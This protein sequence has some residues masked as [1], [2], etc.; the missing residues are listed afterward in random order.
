[1]KIKSIVT[2]TGLLGLAL[3]A[4]TANADVAGYTSNTN[5]QV[6]KKVSSKWLDLSSARG[7]QITKRC[8]FRKGRSAVL[9]SAETG[10]INGPNGGLETR[11]WIDPP[12]AIPAFW[13][14]PANGNL[15]FT[16]YDGSRAETHA[17]HGGFWAKKSGWY[18]V[19]VKVRSTGQSNFNID[20]LSLICMN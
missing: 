3:L 8:Y 4:S 9:F 17:T 20:D 18:N 1:M 11:I 7:N 16:A 14:R 10:H 19:R 5:K 15:F 6:V 12:G 2:S 13:L